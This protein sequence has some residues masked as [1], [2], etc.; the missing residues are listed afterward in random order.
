MKLDADSLLSCRKCGATSPSRIKINSSLHIL[1]FPCGHSRKER[2]TASG[3]VKLTATDIKFEAKKRLF[4]ESDDWAS[5]DGSKLAYE[6]QIDGVKFVERCGGSALIADDMGL[7][8]TIQFLLFLKRHYDTSTPCLITTKSAVVVQFAKEFQQWVSPKLFQVMPIT[9]RAHIIPGFPCYVISH[10]MLAR[11]GVVQKL[12]TIGIKCICVDESQAFKDG[13]SARTKALIDL[14]TLCKIEKRVFLSGT[15]IKSRASEYFTILNLIDPKNFTSKAMFRNYWLDGERIAEHRIEQ[16]RELTKNY[17]IRRLKSEVLTDLPELT[18]NYIRVSIE[19]QRL[20][21]AYNQELR[22]L[23]L[24]LAE[25]GGSI[26]SMHILARLSKL[27]GITARAKLTHA[28]EWI[29]EFREQYPDEKLAA[30]IH[31]T[32]VRDALKYIN[33]DALSLSGEDNSA[34]K[35]EVVNAFQNGDCNLLIMNMIAGGVGLNL[36]AC[37]NAFILERCWTPPDEAQFESRFHRNGQTR[38]VFVTYMMAEGTID[39]WFD[40]LIERKKQI[41]GET[42]DGWTFEGD[43]GAIREFA[44]YVVGRRL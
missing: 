1:M 24:D 36:Q 7:G 40:E 15:P 16:F 11:K 13:D 14:I 17:I 38:P 28:Q 23:E 9:D 5:C 33:P 30:G 22:L 2:F 44:D 20:K 25:K 4:S 32:D 37:A 31:H 18:R 6:Y 12:A 29:N 8:K 41:L 19:D 27:R 34:K 39:V 3:S 10:D 21:D 42:L 43:A 26:S 35:N